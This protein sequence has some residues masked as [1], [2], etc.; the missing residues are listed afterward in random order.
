MPLYLVSYDIAESNHED[1]QPLWDLL[2]VRNAHRLLTSQW[3]VPEA[4]F[5]AEKR[6][7]EAI[8]PLMRD[9]DRLLIARIASGDAKWKHLLLTDTHLGQLFHRP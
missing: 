4:G 9:G 2:R 1:Y 5:D 7:Y 3:I 8:L 6:L